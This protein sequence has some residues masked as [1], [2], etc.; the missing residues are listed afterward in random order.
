VE[1][2]VCPGHDAHASVV[3][4]V[5]KSE[6]ALIVDID[7]ATS[8][9]LGWNAA[10]MVGQTSLD[11]IH[12]DDQQLAVDSWLQMLAA[13]GP[14]RAVRI[15][16]R[17]KDG[18][19]RWVEMTNRNLLDDP[20]FNC[21]VAEMVGV[22]GNTLAENGHTAAPGQKTLDMPV[23][24]LR[25]HEALRA[26][27]QV[28]HRLAEALPLGVLQL[29]EQGRVVY[30]NRMLHT[31]FGPT[32]TSSVA[33]QFSSVV[34]EDRP[35]LSEALEGT[36]RGGLDSDIEVRLTAVGDDGEKETRQC[37][38]S[39][40]AL[41]AEDGAVTGAIACVGDV[42]ESVRIREELRARATYDQL[43]R[44]HNRASTMDALEAALASADGAARPA[45]IF[46]DLDGFKEVND[47]WGHA[48]GDELLTV[49]ARRLRRSVRPEDLVGRIGGDEFLVICPGIGEPGQALRVARRIAQSLGRD[50]QLKRTRLTCRASIGVA[51][52]GGVDEDADLLVSRADRAM[53]EAKRRGDGG[54]VLDRHR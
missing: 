52:P 6:V 29:D 24:P 27:E 51:W 43:T 47:R 50:V 2:G 44:C 25:L 39:L 11:F 48:A 37:T 7:D 42:T 35:V 22:T 26:R 10:E 32:R 19:W 33:E 36:L 14:A 12:P 28:L 18:S 23:Q 34:N 41:T 30:T 17:H 46:V 4:R 8:Q 40:R 13:H 3:A 49:V 20:T 16:H 38:I 21:V 15:R 1:K 53:Y 54:P 5:R 45:V 31:I 9:L